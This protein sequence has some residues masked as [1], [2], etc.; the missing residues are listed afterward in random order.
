MPQDLEL[1]KLRKFLKL[2]TKDLAQAL[3]GMNLCHRTKQGP[4]RGRIV[5]TEAYLFRGDPA[6]HAAQG[7]TPRNAPMFG[8]AGRAYI[9]FIYG[10][11]F[12]F[13]VTSGAEGEGEAVLIRALEP[14]D[15]LE[16]MRRR[17]GAEHL[18]R[19]LTNGPAKLVQALGINKD[20]NTA[21]LLSSELKLELPRDYKALRADSK[22]VSTTRIGISSGADLKL[23]FYLKDSIYVSKK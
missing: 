23:R 19:N 3:L 17:R 22:V 1:A 5:E 6:C 16:E 11:H 15:G 12:C 7:M 14:L 4:I 10:C 2:S 13:N 20:L 18:D 9:Y 8:P 21:C